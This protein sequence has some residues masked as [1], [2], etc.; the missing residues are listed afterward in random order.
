MDDE[1]YEH[2]PWSRLIDEQSDGWKRIVYIVAG[3]VLAVVV[4]IVGIKWLTGPDHG[5]TGASAV[6][7]PIDTT[8]P[9]ETDPND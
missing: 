4:G 7:V 9:N 5:E 2:I 6:S 3:I 1:Q 8:V